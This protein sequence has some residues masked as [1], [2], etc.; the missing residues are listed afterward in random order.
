M[1]GHGAEQ[2]LL[3]QNKLNCVGFTSLRN[4]VVLAIEQR[5][6]VH[7][8]VFNLYTTNPSEK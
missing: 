1:T 7:V 3:E 4:C 5:G 2:V 8:P 6:D